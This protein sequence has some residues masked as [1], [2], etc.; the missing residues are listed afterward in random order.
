MTRAAVRAGFDRFV[1]DAVE[2][3]AE[4]F[5]VARAL[6]RGIDGPGGSVVDRLL[7]DSDAVRKR[8]V[9]PEL[10]TYRR[11]VVAQF[12]AI[13]D[14]A[15]S[16]AGIDAHRESIL[17]RDPFA[18]GIRSDI[19]AERREAIVEGLL[20]RHRRLGEAAAPLID[21]PEDDFWDAVRS[22]LDRETAERLVEE[23][24]VIT[25]PVRNHTDAIEMA[26]TIDPGDV[27]GGLGGLLGGGLP[28]LTVEYTDEAIRA[29]EQ[30]E[31]AV[32]AEA[33]REIDRRFDTSEGP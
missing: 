26:T 31:R 17:E 15:E 6:R 13:L 7:N 16:D 2:A 9:E 3:T 19:S 12:D 5:D 4:H 1:N 33:K 11:R 10:V 23:R 24:F 18:R 27:L 29:M 30:A 20:E 21:A 25:G 8:V 14:F 22:T 32:I 28:T